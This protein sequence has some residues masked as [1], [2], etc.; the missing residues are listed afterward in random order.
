MYGSPALQGAGSGSGGQLTVGNFPVD[1]LT[2]GLLANPA[3]ASPALNELKRGKVG[4]LVDQPHKRAGSE[5]LHHV[6]GAWGEVAVASPGKGAAGWRHGIDNLIV[7]SS[8]EFCA[9]LNFLGICS[10]C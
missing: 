7:P 9:G 1:E 6:G 8:G 10:V 3:A 4:G 5:Q 2:P